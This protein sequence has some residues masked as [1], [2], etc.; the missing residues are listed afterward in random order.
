M[1]DYSRCCNE[2]LLNGLN[3]IARDKAANRDALKRASYELMIELHRE[4]DALLD[5]EMGI[6]REINSRPRKAG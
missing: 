6:Y 4:H 1:A 3:W 2:Q 5:E